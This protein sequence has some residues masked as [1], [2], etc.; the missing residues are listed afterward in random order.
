M[1]TC[2]DIYYDNLFTRMYRYVHVRTHMSMDKNDIVFS[3]RILSGYRY[4]GLQYGTQCFCGNSFGRYGRS[5]NLKDCN[6]PCPA[7]RN[8]I[9]GGTWRNSMYDLQPPGECALGV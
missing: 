9:C 4:F 5:P 7:N 2:Q 1:S 8:E 3:M 6:K